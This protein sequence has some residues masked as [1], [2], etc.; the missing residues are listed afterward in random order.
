M[1]RLAARLLIATLVFTAALAQAGTP[2]FR[3]SFDQRDQHWTALRG[4]AAVD[5]SVLHD[6][7]KSIRVERNV[8]AAT[9]DQDAAIR[10]APV[11]LTMGKR[12]E[13]SGWIR[14]EGLVVRDTDRSPIATGAAI[15]MA[16]MPFDVHSASLGSTKDWTR[17]SLQ[18]VASRSEDQVVLTVG[19]GGSFQ[20][21]AWFEGICVDEAPSA[22][23]SSGEEWPAKDAVQT[24]G[25]AYRYPAA[26]W[27]YL[28][29]EGEPYE[30]GYQHGHLMAREIPE[31]L[32]RCAAVLGSKDR[33]EDYRTTANALFLRGFDHEILEEMRGIAEG[34]SD[35]GA[36]WLDRRI[37]LLD[38]V[39]ANTT[40]E[41]GELPSAI[42]VTPTGLESLN[43]DLP[44]YANTAKRAALDHCSAFAATGPAT[45][46]GKMVIGHVTWWP[47]TLAE[48]TNV[49]L[50]IKPAEGH[51]VLI[52]SY[53]GGIESGTD[54][55][56]N[57]A[58]VVLTE[59]TIDQTPFN[60]RGTPVAFRARKAIQYGSNID[61]VVRILSDQNNGLYTNEWIM[62]DAKTNEIAIFDLGTN[63]TKLWRSSK[64][65]WF[66]NTPGFYWGDNNAKD[67]SVRLEEYPDPK[68][69]PD[70]I[71]YLPGP[72]DTAWQDL[73]RKYHGQ[74]D[75]QFAFLAFRSAP[76]VASSTMDAKVATADMAS[77]MMV[78]AEIGRPNETEWLPNK[79]RD[80]ACDNGLFPSGYY[81]FTA[82][83]SASLR[84]AVQENEKDRQMAS[85]APPK[86]ADPADPPAK[87]YKD[88]LWKGWVLPKSDAD[89]W[90]VAGSAAYERALEAKNVDETMNSQ[91]AVWRGLQ[92]APE[93]PLNRYRR[94]QS[95]G[96]MFLDSLRSKMGDDS[97]FKAMDAFFRENATKT[98]TA[99]AFLDLA[100]AHMGEIDPPDGP[101]YL[102]N[103][104]WRRLP[105][106]VI[107]YGTLRDA[108][109]N[110]YSAE[111]LQSRFLERYQ[112]EVPIYKDFEASDDLLR[113]RDV[114]FVG[115]PEANTALA[116][117]S[118]KLGLDY[119]G[120]D[121][122][123]DSR[124]H[125]DERDALILAGTNPLDPAHMVLIVAG[126]D[127]LSTVKAQSADFNSDE[128]VVLNDTGNQGGFLAHGASSA[129]TTARN[130]VQGSGASPAGGTR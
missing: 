79:K 73:Y 39:V 109:A 86:T 112:S 75:E 83:P 121:F 19:N 46:D 68:G 120:A 44:P 48:Q 64:N 18:F 105:S 116:Q 53:P 56:Q 47:L 98:I 29:I 111:Q 122:K 71:P 106:A 97:F 27:I 37:D 30:R 76:L 127:A 42:S 20:G 11:S 35:A 9:A 55:Y 58:G 59:T 114:V 60:A 89:I 93:T 123:L 61:D 2:A 4:S 126:N 17:V 78:W 41:M 128:Y 92:L 101:A 94:E 91:R 129:P 50:D 124:A 110:R 74:I 45:R 33:W 12:Y 5:A 28:H 117:W 66:G 85:A 40:V 24:F 31:Y 13:L 23:T 21:K 3:S 14:T 88:V 54:W 90:F 15:S 34:A 16:S 118:G 96:V 100:G 102:T 51:R 82:E 104:I 8:S 10:L 70:Y 67:L 125:A 63:H 6:G 115:R 57:D 107:V 87:S 49:M 84:A 36:K 130:P 77:H 108:G 65:E 72:R 43:F 38:V 52:Q 103:D 25:P 69:D 80:F 113:H 119:Q 32:E 99:Q 7:R 95:K 22:N 81:L 26:G 62:G 1:L